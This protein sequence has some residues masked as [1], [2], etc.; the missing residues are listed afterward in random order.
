MI[1][2]STVTPVS[3]GP[4]VNQDRDG[5]TILQHCCSSNGTTD[6]PIE[7]PPGMNIDEPF[8]MMPLTRRVCQQV[9]MSRV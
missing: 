9:L 1:V 2:N 3:K 8:Y 4:D 5:V 7:L 6:T